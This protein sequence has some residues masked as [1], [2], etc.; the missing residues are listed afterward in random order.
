MTKSGQLFNRDRHNLDG[1]PANNCNSVCEVA[2]DGVAKDLMTMSAEASYATAPAGQSG[3]D[4]SVVG[5]DGQSQPWGKLCK[6]A[7]ALMNQKRKHRDPKP[8]DVES[9]R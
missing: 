8:V 2:S 1:N 4:I 5:K 7:Q 6:N 3:C 9:G